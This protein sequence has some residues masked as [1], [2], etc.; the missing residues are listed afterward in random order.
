MMKPGSEDARKRG[1][2]CP[3]IGNHYG[4][5][6]PKPDGGRDYWVNAMCMLHNRRENEATD[7][8]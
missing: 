8:E 6:V 3:V 7:A 5:G 1:C 4:R 2:I